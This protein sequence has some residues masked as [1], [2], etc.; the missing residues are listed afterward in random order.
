[1]LSQ[2]GDFH[3]SIWLTTEIN[4]DFDRLWKEFPDQILVAFPAPFQD[5]YQ[6]AAK[7]SGIDSLRLMAVSRQESSFRAN[8]VSSAG[9]V[10]MMQLLPSTAE[11]IDVESRL[12]I[13]DM[14]LTNPAVNIRLG[15]S[16]LKLLDERYKG[17]RPAVYAAYNAGEFAVDVWLEKRRQEDPTLW[18]EL[19]PFGET[20][21]YVK[22]VWR[23]EVIYRYLATQTE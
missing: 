15:A 4:K 10:G 12:N 18:N 8:V 9:A 23:N 3:R 22:N 7:E 14:D 1:M 20:N 11:R 2:S 16:Y 17:F 6:T 13:E 19:I 21:N 5:F